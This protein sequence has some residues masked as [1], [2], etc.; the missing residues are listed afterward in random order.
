MSDQSPNPKR[1]HAYLLLLA[2][3]CPPVATLLAALKGITIH[4]LTDNP[5]MASILFV[6]YV[7]VL[8]IISVWTKFWPPLGEELLNWFRQKVKDFALRLVSRYDHHYRKYFHSEHRNL[9]VKGLGTQGPYALDLKRIFVELGIDP[10]STDQVSPNPLR[11]PGTLLEGSHT[12]CDYLQAQQIQDQHIVVLGA[13]GN[14]KTTLLKHLGLCLLHHKPY[15]R[16][17]LAYRLP[18]LLFL[19]EHSE[20]IADQSTPYGL[21]DAVRASAAKW[22]R[23]MPP[24]WIEQHLGK[25]H[26][27]ILL[28]G[29]D[30]VAEEQKRRHVV[31]WVR[32]QMTAYTLNRFIVTSRPYGYDPNALDNVTILELQPFMPT[33]IDEFV[34]N[35]YL[36]NETKSAMRSDHGIHK[37]AREAAE[38]LL[39]HLRGTPGLIE[40]AVNPLLLTIIVTVYCYSKNDSIPNTR[41][42]LYQRICEVFLGKRRVELGIQQVIQPEQRQPVLQALAYQMMLDGIKEIAAADAQKII[43][44]P[45]RQASLSPDN[46][47]QG[48]EQV[49][50]LLLERERGTYIF[51][52]RTFQEYLTMMHI[53]QQGLGQQ[54]IQCVDDIWWHEVIRLYCAQAEA[55]P[56]IDACLQRA[57][58]SV[59]A[60]VLALECKEEALSVQAETAK[61]LEDLLTS[62]LENADSQRRRV[63]AEAILARRLKQMVRLTGEI[64]VDSSLIS[65]AEYQ[66]FLD[67]Q[68]RGSWHQP[69]HW[70]QTSFKA[71]LAQ[72]PV[73]GIRC[74]DAQAFCAWLT[75]RESGIWQYR[76]PKAGEVKPENIHLS[77]GRQT[78][79]GFWEDGENM[80]TWIT[81]QSAQDGQ[82]SQKT[83]HSLYPLDLDLRHI[84]QVRNT[85]DESRKIDLDYVRKVSGRLS[86]N[87]AIPLFSAD[88]IAIAISNARDISSPHRLERAIAS[89]IA[90]SSAIAITIASASDLAYELSSGLAHDLSS[91]LTKAGD[92]ARVIS[93]DLTLISDHARTGDQARNFTSYLPPL[94]EA[95]DLA[96]TLTKISFITIELAR[97]RNHPYRMDFIVFTQLLALLSHSLEDCFLILSST[98]PMPFWERFLPFRTK[99]RSSPLTPSATQKLTNLDLC[100][101]IMSRLDQFERRLRGEESAYEGLIIVKERR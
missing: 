95:N 74:S 97:D 32:E 11:L 49:G 99:G 16:C 47:L 51:A 1:W 65:C 8:G 40:L 56:I 36:A 87:L 94:D 75:Q 93:S 6:L 90:I 88:A 13:P 42:E 66:L 91:D 35:W 2:A 9:D 38:K 26:C 60:L 67:L 44:E 89:A 21:A 80:F 23:V 100:K 81:G 73:L 20:K 10:T 19:R 76:L 45:L 17:R 62:G 71:G 4:G 78:P 86:R 85:K 63:T 34:Y 54:L 58:T 96:D 7:I 98:L 31:A 30:E 33:Q 22:K 5:L 29:L 64:Y 101:E 61:S 50:G 14:G 15:C 43:Q 18:V 37:K 41:V 82:F 53:Q 79:I 12:I 24:E 3:I 57:M 92:L 48:I 46:F 83:D 69:D 77:A 25:G 68:A 39:H 72:E 28:D 59:P 70:E 52:H 84:R 55:T 27:L